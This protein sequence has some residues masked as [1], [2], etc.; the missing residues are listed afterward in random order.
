MWR[1]RARC[2]RAGRQHKL[3]WRREAGSEHGFSAQPLRAIV[4]ARRPGPSRSGLVAA[5]NQ[6]EFTWRR[7][8]FRAWLGVVSSDG[9]CPCDAH[10][11]L[12][13]VMIQEDSARMEVPNRCIYQPGR[14]RDGPVAA[15]RW[16]QRTVD[17]RPTVNWQRGAR[18]SCRP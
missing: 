1:R 6:F 17:N 9:E 16:S 4:K 11:A 8:E 15:C 7:L 10:N 18:K 2:A 13:R 14:E 5:D 12:S 3:G